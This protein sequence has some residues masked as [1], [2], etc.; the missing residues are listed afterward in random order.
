MSL[1]SNVIHKMRGGTRLVDAV[2]IA[3]EDAKQ[4][5]IKSYTTCLEQAYNMR[6]SDPPPM[7]REELAA[8]E[9][10]MNTLPKKLDNYNRLSDGVKDAFLKAAYDSIHLQEGGAIQYA[11]VFQMMQGYMDAARTVGE[12]AEEA[13]AKFK[14]SVRNRMGSGIEG[15]SVRDN[16]IEGLSILQQVDHIEKM[17]R[18]KAVSMAW[19]SA[20]ENPGLTTQMPETRS[21]IVVET[22]TMVSE[23]MGIENDISGKITE[24]M[25]Y[26]YNLRRNYEIFSQMAHEGADLLQIKEALKNTMTSGSEPADVL[27]TR[28]QFFVEEYNAHQGSRELSLRFMAERM[29]EFNRM[30][31]A[32]TVGKVANEMDVNPNRNFI[33]ADYTSNFDVIMEAI[34]ADAFQNMVG[35]FHKD[36]ELEES[37]RQ[38]EQHN[39]VMFSDTRLVDTG[40]LVTDP[41]TGRELRSADGKPMHKYLFST[42]ALFDNGLP[43]GI[44]LKFDIQP[45]NKIQ[46]AQVDF[47]GQKLDQATFLKTPEIQHII[48]QLPPAMRTQMEKNLVVRMEN[49]VYRP[50]IL[51][52]AMSKEAVSFKAAQA[53]AEA[54]E[55][56]FQITFGSG[57]APDL[58]PEKAPS[59]PMESV[60]EHDDVH[61]GLE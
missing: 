57:K 55:K 23:L 27:D 24:G 54:Q 32:S 42:R 21:S 1:L 48:A 61:I 2:M 17:V 31:E 25:Q 34:G 6:D 4:A 36:K 15:R 7:S 49:G 13:F 16:N 39:R 52:N 9:E 14:E 35:M 56:N 19:Q 30:V 50:G 41:K 44:E 11:Q 28:I 37:L 18:D 53:L 20:Q 8:F 26:L 33:G 5:K 10:R 59:K 3:I 38:I 43:S 12:T 58:A 46:L 60:M 45:D 51:A 22:K 47:H 40:L 29:S